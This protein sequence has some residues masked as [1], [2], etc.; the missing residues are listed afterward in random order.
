MEDLKKEDFLRCL[1]NYKEAYELQKNNYEEFDKEYKENC[2]Q[3]ILFDK[4]F[5][6]HTKQSIDTL[7]KE[8][9]D[10]ADSSLKS[11]NETKNALIKITQKYNQLLSI[12]I[13]RFGTIE[14]YEKIKLDI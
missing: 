2:I 14:G 12:T 11:R 1:Q 7:F 10:K 4:P 13:E 5:E 8:Y 9:E 6:G 3:T